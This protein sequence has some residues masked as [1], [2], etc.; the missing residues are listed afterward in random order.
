MLS[1]VLE[2][3]M[4]WGVF[5]L[6]F[7]LFLRKLTFFTFNR[8]YLISSLLLGLALP[9]IS[10][11]IS[12][13]TPVMEE[14]IYFLAP[15]S[16]SPALVEETLNT[17]SAGI[18]YDK[19]FL[20]IY[21][22]GIT[23]FG[24]QFFIGL[25][26]I[27]QLYRK[28][29]KIQK[30]NYTLVRTK[31]LHLP[32]SFF[33]MVFWSSDLESVQEGKEKIMLH[34]LSHVQDR[35][36]YDV[37]LIEIIRIFLWCS[38]FIYWYKKSMR[39]IHEY[40]ADHTV[41][42]TT[43]LKSYGHLLLKQ[44]QSGMQLTLANH[45]IHSQ[46]KNRITM[47]LQKPSGRMAKLKYLLIL[48]VILGLGLLI[49]AKSI[50]QQTEPKYELLNE[51]IDQ[52]HDFSKL[53]D[54]V[55]VYSDKIITGD[56][57][58]YKIHD[59]RLEITNSEILE[60][61]HPIEV[62]YDNNVCQKL[63]KVNTVGKMP[64]YFRL[65]DIDQNISEYI[66]ENLHYRT[67]DFVRI[68]VRGGQYFENSYLTC[69]DEFAEIELKSPG[70]IYY[71]FGETHTIEVSDEDYDETK[72]IV[73]YDVFSDGKAIQNVI[74]PRTVPKDNVK[75]AV[76]PNLSKSLIEGS[77]D[78]FG[79][80]SKLEYSNSK[81]PGLISILKEDGTVVALFRIFEYEGGIKKFMSDQV[82]IPSDQIIRMDVS[83]TGEGNIAAR[84]AIFEP[85][86]LI[87]IT[88]NNDAKPE[89]ITNL[90]LSYNSE[91]QEGNQIVFDVRNDNIDIKKID[92]KL[93]LNA[94]N[95]A[96]PPPH[97][98]ATPAE[99]FGTIE[100]MPRFPGCEDL[101]SAKE[102]E[103]CAQ[104]KLLQFIYTNIR[105]PKESREAGV[106]GMNIVQFVVEKDGSLS[107]VK[108]MKSIDKHTANE[109]LRIV[110]LMA[111]MPDKWTPGTLNGEPVRTTFNLPIKFK[112]QGKDDEVVPRDL[113][114]V[115]DK[116]G[117]VYGHFDKTMIDK[118]PTDVILSVNVLKGEHARNKYTNQNNLNSV[119]EV[120]TTWGK[121]DFFMHGFSLSQLTVVGYGSKKEK[122]K[123]EEIYKVVDQMPRF[124]GCE[125]I[126]GTNTEK[127]E[128]AKE[129]MLQFIYENIRYPKEAKDNG[130]Q[131]MNVVRFV[132]EKDGTL[133]RFEVVRKIDEST[134]KE[135]IRIL[136]LMNEMEQ[137]W[138][139]G[140]HKGNPV[141]VQYNLPIRFKL[142]DDSKS[143]TTRSGNE[144]LSSGKVVFLVFD[145]N[146]EVLMDFEQSKDIMTKIT[147]ESIE[148]VNVFKGNSLVK[149]Y[150]ERS[151]VEGLVEIH[152]KWSKSKFN[153]QLKINKENPQST[154]SSNPVE[155][156]TNLG[157]NPTNLMS[158]NRF[159][160]FPNP[161]NDRLNVSFR[162]DPGTLKWSI[163]D[164]S[165]KEIF[166]DVIRN[167]SGIFNETVELKDA[168]KGAAIMKFEQEGKQY[169]HKVIV[170]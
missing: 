160:A 41:L 25:N 165:G 161:T 17:S 68:D 39:Q 69:S 115:F 97:P 20:W 8:W 126:S 87:Q 2:V 63:I 44:S 145:K 15:I 136:K 85:D 50:D 48:P 6:I 98:I 11:N 101:G 159:Q 134:A 23:I 24:A 77:K 76:D 153:R 36:S 122:P 5:S 96:P 62:I 147:P 132:I 100:I 140:H 57:I 149:K 16:N 92:F 26:K 7:H 157:F 125:E 43:Q 71:K 79:L 164:S 91:D 155:T 93:D 51:A 95:F 158:L 61:G 13:P 88:I 19:I 121:E 107:N 120:H 143:S 10:F 109:A 103:N 83:K 32:F 135:S 22:I 162:S 40:I 53:L 106:E 154:D 114:I 56:K 110:K 30:S 90:G 124:P 21:W 34:E 168:A 49:S 29:E 127:D 150:P 31:S 148:S 138:T 89:F 170:Q 54:N 38:P 104:K 130:I 113:V 117:T 66:K 152:L 163:A 55:K 12:E 52:T 35:H 84:Y 74:R 131:G 156:A 94:K 105:Y 167:F 9:L 119:T 151:G 65:Y 99:M 112:L 59:G 64:I 169:I 58:D 118:L 86:Q 4:Y 18:P 75:Q 166:T 82:L 14:T 137:K 133:S 116:E 67:E 33:N 142:S 80:K 1:Y 47:M 73:V 108:V 78:L 102:V 45:F 37:L 139:P 111:A 27:F 141:P 81:I 42:K 129:K 60:S 128:C 46:L 144:S 72:D 123:I 70:L 3:T 146:G 28:G